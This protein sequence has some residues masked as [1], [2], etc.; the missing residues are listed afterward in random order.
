MYG[1]KQKIIGKM[2]GRDFKN[3]NGSMNMYIFNTENGRTKDKILDITEAAT[4]EAKLWDGYGTALKPAY[5]PIVVAFKPNEGTFAQNALKY[6]VAGLNIDDARIEIKD[7]KNG[8][9]KNEYTSQCDATSYKMRDDGDKYTKLKHGKGRFP[10]NI[11]LDEESANILD[12]QNEIT[13]SRV[14]KNVRPKQVNSNT[15]IKF[16]TKA[17]AKPNINTHADKGGAS[18]YF[19][20]IPLDSRI[21]YTP[22]TS[23]KERDAGCDELKNNHPTVKPIALLEYLCNLTKTPTG[24]IVLDPFLGS[25]TT[26]IACVNTKRSYIGIEQDKGYCDIAEKRI[27]YYKNK[28]KELLF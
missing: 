7:T 14:C 13:I 26:A 24:G 15:E 27:N 11:I 4:P 23:K 28:Q 18:R 5:E 12:E 17:I 10:A 1:V 22:K 19:K 20:N 21:L 8:F 2:N 9:R 16:N 3:H 25:G 6:G